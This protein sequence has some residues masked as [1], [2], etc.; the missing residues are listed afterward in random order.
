MIAL[1]SAP[2]SGSLKFQVTAEADLLLDAGR[3]STFF[4]AAEAVAL[5]IAFLD[6]LVS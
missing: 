1:T 3:I 5:S 6:S 4:G 2:L